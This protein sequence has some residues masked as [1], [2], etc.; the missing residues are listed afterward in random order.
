M[1]LELTDIE[2]KKFLSEYSDWNKI[3]AS[4]YCGCQTTLPVVKINI[5]IEKIDTFIWNIT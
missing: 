1:I 2:F 4:T 5:S 3:N